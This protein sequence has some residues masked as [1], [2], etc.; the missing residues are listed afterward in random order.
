[1][2]LLV[3]ILLA[4]LWTVPTSDDEIHGL[5]TYMNPGKL[6]QA[7]ARMGRSLEGVAGGV[8]LNRK[9]DIGRLVWIVRDGITYGPLRVVDCA[10]AGEHYETR[11]AQGRVVEVSFE[12]AQEW[13]IVGVGPTPV[14][15]LFDS[16]CA[17]RPA[18]AWSPHP[19]PMEV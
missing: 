1:M 18:G 6:E 3:P 15:V 12:L 5:A 19:I 13:G 8:A 17:A 11:E 2:K 16:P 7:A 4:A 9:G 14:T 10:Q